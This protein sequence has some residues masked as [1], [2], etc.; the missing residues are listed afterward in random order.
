VPVDVVAVVVV[1]VVIGR[2]AATWAAFAV[3]VEPFAQPAAATMTVWPLPPTVTV[4]TWPGAKELC[5]SDFPSV[6]VKVC[7]AE[8]VPSTRARWQDGVVVVLAA[9]VRRGG[10][11]VRRPDPG[12]ADDH[13]QQDS[14][15][16]SISFRVCHQSD[17]EIPGLLRRGV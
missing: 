5:W 11:R 10:E 13:E 15:L 14:E 1:M 7:G 2:N 3:S 6:T 9:V 16:H 12:G 17:A 8:V 4:T